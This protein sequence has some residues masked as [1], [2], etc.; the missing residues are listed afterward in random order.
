MAE[1]IWYYFFGGG[2]GG[3]I[4]YQGHLDISVLCM[5]YLQKLTSAFFPHFNGKVSV[6]KF[7]ESENKAK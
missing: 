1:S 2:I 6:S 4:I 3:T 5:K 7:Q